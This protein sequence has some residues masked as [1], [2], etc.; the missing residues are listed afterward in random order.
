MSIFSCHIFD[1]CLLYN[2]TKACVEYVERAPAEDAAMEINKA[3]ILFKEGK[4]EQALER[5]KKA[6]QILGFRPDISYNI[7]VCFYKLKQ[8]DN[9]LKHIADII[10]KG[11]K[12]AILGLFIGM[13]LLFHC[14]LNQR[15][16]ICFWSITVT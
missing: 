5:F 6:Q 15:C 10:E 8:Y 3:C 1:A 7:A 9:S 13:S 12:V 14:L 4:F 11:I 16:V 2:S